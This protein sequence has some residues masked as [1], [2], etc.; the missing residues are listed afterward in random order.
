[1]AVDRAQQPA[2]A[3][4][5]HWANLQGAKLPAPKRGKGSS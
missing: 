3:A 4:P 1:M 5:Y 2:A